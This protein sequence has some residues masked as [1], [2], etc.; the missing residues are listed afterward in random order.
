[1]E[2]EYYVTCNEF[3]A[4]QLRNIQYVTAYEGDTPV[5]NTI[6]YSIETYLYN[7]QD[8]VQYGALVRAIF[9]YGISAWNYVF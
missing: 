5:S 2:N 3:N 7:M 1:M 6:T 8:D 4:T 9:H